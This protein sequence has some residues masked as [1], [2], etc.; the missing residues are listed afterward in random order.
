MITSRFGTPLADDGVV[1]AR[2]DRLDRA[3]SR[4]I[5]L[6]GL[7]FS[8]I[9][10]VDEVNRE[11]P[12][13]GIWRWGFVM[14][15]AFFVLAAIAPKQLSQLQMR[16]LWIAIPALGA[17]LLA[18]TFSADRGFKGMEVWD[19][20]W[21]LVAVYLCFLVL[22]VRGPHPLIRINLFAAAFAVLPA[23]TY[24]WLFGSFKNWMPGITAVIFSNV[25]YAMLLALFRRRMLAYY[26]VQER[27][28]QRVLA[29]AA[30]EARL[31]EER[32]L[33]RLAHD[34]VLGT[35]NAAAMWDG[36]VPPQLREMAEGAVILLDARSGAASSDQ[37]TDE[38]RATVAKAAVAL[39][40]DC[41]LD[42]ISDGAT[43]PTECAIAIV[44][45]T[46][47]ALRN[48]VRHAPNS[49]RR[50]SAVLSGERVVVTITDDGDGFA[51]ENVSNDRL[52]VANS[53]ITRMH[54]LPGGKAQ[55][56]SRPG[57]G[58]LVHLTWTRSA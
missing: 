32:E 26:T 37:L 14:L 29:S 25:G 36:A 27:W 30:S 23:L 50:L 33:A 46:S 18:T 52:G 20:S 35:L 17:T 12:H 34:R 19:S 28:R 53:I 58:T 55:V 42:L 4:I 10:A 38:V 21:L 8:V 3:S 11:D 47:E 22:G 51:P 45:A 44:D 48:S 54:D 40:P 16:S 6:G 2:T 5:A 24:V 13:A 15:I 57:A 49:H 7:G 1:A 31:R 56:H 43:I 39:D 9:W 41:E